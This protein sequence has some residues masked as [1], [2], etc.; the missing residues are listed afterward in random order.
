MTSNAAVPEEVLVHD[1]ALRRDVVRDT[2]KVSWSSII[3]GL[4]VALGTWVL[5]SVLGLALGLSQADPNNP[6]SLHTAGMVT[7]IWSVIVPIVA[8][9][10]GGLVAAR[11]AG[12]VTRPTGAIHGVVL[13]ALVTIASLAMVGYV[14]KGVVSTAVNAGAGLASAAGANAGPMANAV[15]DIAESLGIRQQDILG[16]VNDRLR[17]EGKPTVSPREMD[18]TIKDVARTSVRE[19]R[20]DRDVIVTAV[21]RNT[22][23]SSTDAEDVAN[24]IETQVN[25]QGSQMG[26]NIQS[27]FAKAADTTGHAMWWVFLGMVLGLGAAVVGSTLGVSRKQRLA[28]TTPPETYV[29]HHPAHST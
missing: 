24:R 23:L 9:L 19:G 12:I 28:A 22:R 21:T 26:Q 5:L 2:V 16:P 4:F 27:G 14:V 10:L 20:I 29:T 15:P 25:Q 8:L 1:E 3:A 7:G 17:S 11:T 18:A 13:W 6:S